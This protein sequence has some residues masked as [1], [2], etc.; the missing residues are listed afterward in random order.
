V[1]DLVYREGLS[2]AQVA[3]RLGITRNAVDQA[4]HNG[5]RKLVEKLIA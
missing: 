3:E 1:L 5:H 4:L 2:L